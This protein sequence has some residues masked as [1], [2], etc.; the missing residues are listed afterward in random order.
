LD[1]IVR[2][3]LSPSVKVFPG[4]EAVNLPPVCSVGLEEVRNYVDATLRKG[5]DGFVLSWDIRHISDAILE[6]VGD[7]FE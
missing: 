3:S 5:H 7:R 2:M 1:K 6:Y 4:F